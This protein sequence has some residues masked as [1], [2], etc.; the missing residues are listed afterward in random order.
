MRFLRRARTLSLSAD[1]LL[2][3]QTES[4]THILYSFANVKPD[5]GEVHLTDA[6]A[7]EQIH[8]PGDDWNDK[9]ASESLYGNLKALYLMKKK[10]RHLKSEYLRFGGNRLAQSGANFLSP[11]LFSSSSAPLLMSVFAFQFLP[12]SHAL[13]WG[14]DLLSQLRRSCFYS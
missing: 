14:M 13:D 3:S 9:N 5:S 8:Y 4:L 7:D 1:Y 12:H 2:R 10:H 6:W 11:S